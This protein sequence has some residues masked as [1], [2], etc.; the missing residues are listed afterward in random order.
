MNRMGWSGV[1]LFAMIVAGAVGTACGGSSQQ[2]TTA[3][4]G[5]GVEGIPADSNAEE[6]QGPEAD[7]LRAF[8]RHHHGGGFI[9]FALV[10]IPTLGVSPAE[11]ANVEKIRADMQAKLQP[12]HDAMAAL[13]NIVADGVAAGAIDHAKVDAAIA[14]ITQV[15][16][17]MDDVTNDALNQLHA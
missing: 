12:A 4:A 13:T 10:S 9:T 3:S 7:A 2:P 6:E 1:A 5:A 14:N 11:A 17:Q 8:H 16:T 15:S